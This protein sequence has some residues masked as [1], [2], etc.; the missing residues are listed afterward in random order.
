[1]TIKNKKNTWWVYLVRCNDNSLYT[2]VTTDIERRI[3]EHNTSKLGAKYTRARRPVYLAYL[4]ALENKS[5]AC[6]REYIIRNLNKIK[7]ED[8]VKQEAMK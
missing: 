3:K 7:K 4:E 1:M 8:L 5:L 2:G 6:K